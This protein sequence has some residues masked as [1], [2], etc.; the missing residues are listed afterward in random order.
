MRGVAS[1]RVS[2]GTERHAWV[3]AGGARTG[4]GLDVPRVPRA[5]WRCVGG[6]GGNGDRTTRWQREEQIGAHTLGTR[7]YLSPS[8]SPSFSSRSPHL[9]ASS[10]N[11][12]RWQAGVVLCLLRVKSE[13]DAE[14]RGW[15][16]GEGLGRRRG[17]SAGCARFGGDSWRRYAVGWPKCAGDFLGR[18]PNSEM[19]KPIRN[20][21]S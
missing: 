17:V 12:R 19:S 6:R 20:I 16:G 3:S 21:D 4:G 11:L 1:A 18:M 14:G 5:H 9:S 13:V 10:T 15:G 2:E 7:L 8:P